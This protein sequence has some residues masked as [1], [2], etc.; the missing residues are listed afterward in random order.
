M[1]E[2]KE[3]HIRGFRRLLDVRLP[4]RPFQVIIG[5]NGGGKTSVLDAVALLAAASR[6]QLGAKLADYGGLA[7][8]LTRDRA[9]TVELEVTTVDGTANPIT[10]ALAI[11]QRGPGLLGPAG[12]HSRSLATCRRRSNHIDSLNGRERYF[13]PNKKGLVPLDE[14]DLA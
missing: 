13:D 8:T 2:L 12:V 7:D 3:I 6:G 11:Q 1:V 10:Y 9:E 5:V 4:A 14:G